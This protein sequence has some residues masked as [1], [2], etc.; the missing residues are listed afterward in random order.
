MSY[1]DDDKW[2]G[3]LEIYGDLVIQVLDVKFGCYYLPVRQAEQEAIVDPIVGKP[4][5]SVLFND[6]QQWYRNT[7]AKKA[8]D[9]RLKKINP[10]QFIYKNRMEQDNLK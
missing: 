1:G 8:R 9:R 5:Q 2:G 3:C 4:D 10:L 6:I 7:L